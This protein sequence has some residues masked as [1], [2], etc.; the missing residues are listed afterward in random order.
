MYTWAFYLVTFYNEIDKSVS[1][2]FV[3]S[4]DIERTLELFRLQEP[5]LKVSSYE[6]R[7]P[8]EL[9]NL[10]IVIRKEPPSF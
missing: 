4:S 10:F 3:Y 1:C 2:H 9:P 8:D 5:H 7:T 6:H